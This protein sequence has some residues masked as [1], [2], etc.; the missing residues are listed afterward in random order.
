MWALS[1]VPRVYYL[2]LMPQKPFGFPTPNFKKGISSPHIPPPPD[3]PKG[4][5]GPRNENLR[6]YRKKTLDG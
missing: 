4:K 6:I 1:R 5:K 3:F 2:G